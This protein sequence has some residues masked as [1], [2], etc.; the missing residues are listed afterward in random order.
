MACGND[1]VMIPLRVCLRGSNYA[2]VH[3]GRLQAF[4]Q[5]QSNQVTKTVRLPVQP[6]PDVVGTFSYIR[7][8]THVYS[9]LVQ[10]DRPLLNAVI[11]RPPNPRASDCNGNGAA[12]KE[13]PPPNSDD[14][15]TWLSVGA[16]HDGGALADLGA[17]GE[18]DTVAVG[19]T[20][21]R[22]HAG[23]RLLLTAASWS[24][25]QHLRVGITSDSV[26][27]RKSHSNLIAS[28]EE[29]AHN[30]TTFVKSVNPTLSNVT[31]SFLTDSTGPAAIDPT[32]DALVVSSET[33]LGAR[34]IN[35]ARLRA[36]LPPLS[37]V[38][39]DVLRTRQSK[40]SSTALREMESKHKE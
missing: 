11:H 5:R 12:L 9:L 40:L 39:V 29:R 35:D 37:L 31:T 38:V 34:T 19:G 2:H 17:E 16:G 28:A 13:L 21:D 32:I 27:S 24:C 4:L 25:R 18:Y 26:L 14:E 36:G 7:L 33:V 10:Y 23:H 30:T 8:A 3:V 15:D 20:F 22:L 6:D 1:D